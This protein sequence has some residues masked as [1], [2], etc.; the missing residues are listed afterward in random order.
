MVEQDDE[1]A[2]E[3]DLT[4]LGD[5]SSDLSSLDSDTEDEGRDGDEENG[6]IIS[7]ELQFSKQQLTQ[8]RTSP[9]CPPSL[10]VEVE[11][12]SIGTR[13][14]P[15]H[16]TRPF[17]YVNYHSS[18]YS[19]RSTLAVNTPGNGPEQRESENNSEKATAEQRDAENNSEKA[20]ESSKAG[21]KEIKEEEMDSTGHNEASNGDQSFHGGVGGSGS[22]D[23]PG[24]EDKRAKLPTNVDVVADV[25]MEDVEE[26]EEREGERSVEAQEEAIPELSESCELAGRANSVE[27][28]AA[29]ML[30]SLFGGLGEANDTPPD[31]AI[32]S[33]PSSLDASPAPSSVDPTAERTLAPPF[34]VERKR[35]RRTSKDVES[36]KVELD[37]L[38]ESTPRLTRR[39]S[40][41]YS[42]GADERLATG[43]PVPTPS[44]STDN[45][46][47]TSRPGR[48]QS[49]KIVKDE[50]D[51]GRSVSPRL[52]SPRARSKARQTS[53]GSEAR[54]TRR[55]HPMAGTVEDL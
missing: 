50:D 35:S 45:L 22:G 15:S 44:S 32:L 21:D 49:S 40:R 8:G 9:E 46:S 42:N 13:G 14:P 52:M 1:D 11:P 6:R 34:V 38:F 12:V 23:D 19:T 33:E 7:P 10:P 20:G 41:Q 54:G 24:D 28:S 4:D 31:H 36:A 3:S 39:Q 47:M 51:E 43:S 29:E 2:E 30:V 26:E 27:L 48:R 5:E 16:R 37:E 53:F 55:S 18:P 17:R 25:I